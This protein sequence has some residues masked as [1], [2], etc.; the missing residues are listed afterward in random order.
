MFLTEKI[1][2]RPSLCIAVIMAAYHVFIC[3][4]SRMN[5]TTLLVWSLALRSSTWSTKWSSCRFGTLQDKNG[6]GRE[7][8][9]HNS[10]WLITSW[11]GCFCYFMCITFIYAIHCNYCNRGIV[12]FSSFTCASKGGND[13]K[14]RFGNSL[15]SLRPHGPQVTI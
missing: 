7:N 5:L 15:G 8:S 6:S 1:H 4:K 9:Q 14:K 11:E 10:T 2:C 12:Y 3:F 13:R